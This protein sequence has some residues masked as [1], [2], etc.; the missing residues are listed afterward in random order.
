[1]VEQVAMFSGSCCRILTRSLTDSSHAASTN[2]ITGTFLR[3][4]DPEDSA[5]QNETAAMEIISESATSL[6]TQ[7][8]GLIPS[9]TTLIAPDFLILPI[10][11]F[12]ITPRARVLAEPHNTTID[13]FQTITEQYNRVLLEGAQALS[14][15]LSPGSRGN[16]FTYDVVAWMYAMQAHPERYDL[17][18]A[19]D[20]CT[21][22]GCSNAR[23]YLFWQVRSSL[24]V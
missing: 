15:R 10:L 1:M 12:Q 18:T 13:M 8:E 11:P 7:L 20:G 16:V 21:V 2:P 5:Y 24:L 6:T 14:D 17:K 22:I 19:T 3:F 23:D 4:W 9:D